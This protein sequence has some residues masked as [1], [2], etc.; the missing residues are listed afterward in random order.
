M[1]MLDWPPGH[2]VWYSWCKY[3]VAGHGLA[4]HN[5]VAGHNAARRVGVVWLHVEVERVLVQMMVLLSIVC[6]SMQHLLCVCVLGHH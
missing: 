3:S 1:P 6:W 4:G 2:H 5:G